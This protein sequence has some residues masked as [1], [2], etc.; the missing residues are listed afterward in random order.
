MGIK[1]KRKDNG[2]Y[3]KMQ[4]VMMLT[5]LLFFFFFFWRANAFSVVSSCV[6]NIHV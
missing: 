6:L 3:I 4:E 5:K 2:R 1:V